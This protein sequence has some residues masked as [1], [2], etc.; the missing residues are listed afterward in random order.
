MSNIG[1][2]N[3]LFSATK[4]LLIAVIIILMGCNKDTPTKISMDENALGEASKLNQF[5][6]TDCIIPMAK[7]VRCGYVNVPENR[8]SAE[9]RI[10][11]IAV[12]ILPSK[13]KNPKPDPVVIL[14]GGPGFPLIRMHD[15]IP[16]MLAPILAKRDIIL[17]DQR[18]VGFSTPRISCPEVT[19]FGSP[20]PNMESMKDVQTCYD[21]LIASGTDLNGYT[22]RENAADFDVV[23]EALGYQE[24]NLL[25]ASYGVLL[26]LEIMHNHPD[27]LR[28]VILDSAFPPHVN[29]ISD[30]GDILGLLGQFIDNC[31]AD[32]TCADKHPNLEKQINAFANTLEKQGDKAPIE[33]GFL[34][35]LLT[36][37]IND[38]KLPDMIEDF[39]IGKNPAMHGPKEESSG[40]PKE[41]ISGWGMATSILCAEEVAYIDD[42]IDKKMGHSRNTRWSP[43][44]Y[45]D[46]DKVTNLSKVMCNIWDVQPVD[47]AQDTFVT[48]VPA[49]IM[50]SDID[51]STPIQWSRETMRYL[52]N[53]HMVEL[54]GLGHVTFFARNPCPST[55]MAKY[56]DD[57]TMSPN[58][59]EVE[60]CKE[61]LLAER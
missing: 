35:M 20:V 33:V 27:G 10:I 44:F 50:A 41:D 8:S 24:W 42:S 43:A 39:S 40:P 13:N 22:T 61:M 7:R 58:A 1:N 14:S 26:G 60:S 54:K 19:T 48:D 2:S 30:H 11:K 53:G 38:P 17:V 55:I 29:G 4:S 34:M 12:A 25:G 47:G 5:V 52:K 45:N 28:S 9:S 32:K 6:K 37:N 49:L 46:L 31:N 16:K 51:S 59:S 57:P 3:L 36:S 21:R 23:R 15:V 56:L 18:G